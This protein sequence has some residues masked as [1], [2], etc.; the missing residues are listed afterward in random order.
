MERYECTFDV[1]FG[2]WRKMREEFLD[3]QL[4]KDVTR[5]DADVATMIEDSEKQ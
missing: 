5:F 4:N 2:I 3:E 1:F